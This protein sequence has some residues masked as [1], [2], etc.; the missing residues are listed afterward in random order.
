MWLAHLRRFK[1]GEAVV[2]SRLARISDWSLLAKKA[3][4]NARELAALCHVSLRQLERYYKQSF[5]QSPQTWLNAARLKEAQEFLLQ[6]LTVKETAYS[7]GFKQPSHFCREFKRHAGT[8]PNG[9]VLRKSRVRP[10]NV[11]RR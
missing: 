1:K 3:Q 8:T 4:Y 11:V 7:V 10:R 9:F 2:G 5:D 6:G